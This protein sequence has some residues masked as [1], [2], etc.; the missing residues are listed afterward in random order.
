MR[1]TTIDG[2]FRGRKSTGLRSIRS[3]LGSLTSSLQN[4][5]ADAFNARFAQFD[6]VHAALQQAIA[7]GTLSVAPAVE[8]EAEFVALGAERDAH[9]AQLA[10]L[11]SPAQLMEWHS[12]G[13]AIVSR[14]NAL[15]SSTAD[16][17]G[18]STG[19][20]PWQ[21]GVAIVGGALLFGGA[22]YLLSRP[23]RRRK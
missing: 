15:A 21:I 22:A 2:G 11:D 12:T 23:K 8:L 13:D 6:Q 20:R 10:T 5:E 17:I 9:R 16:A 1:V 19:T 3:G 4:S 7:N 18:F 14:A